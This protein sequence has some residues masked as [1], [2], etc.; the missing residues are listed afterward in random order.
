[1]GCVVDVA[2]SCGFMLW[3]ITVCVVGV[4]L[5]CRDMTACVVVVALALERGGFVHGCWVC[6]E[7]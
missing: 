5:C 2:L 1:M 7:L 4:M 6:G 3:S